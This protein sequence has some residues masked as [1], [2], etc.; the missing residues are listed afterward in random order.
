MDLQLV[1]GPVARPTSRAA[2][3]I[4]P[5]IG[6]AYAHGAMEFRFYLESGESQ[7][8]STD[9]DSSVA[10]DFRHD[11][12]CPQ[13]K[14]IEAIDDT[15]M[16]VNQSVKLLEQLGDTP[17][18]VARSLHVLGI[19][20][21]RN[22]VR[23]LNPI[24]RY[25]QSHISDEGVELDLIHGTAVTAKTRDRLTKAIPVPEPVKKFL[26]AFHSGEYPSCEMPEE[27]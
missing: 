22:T 9:R 27:K 23:F 25:L 7:P 13:E 15:R 21:V 12:G 14:S 19:Q 10:L 24:I 18:A 5:P 17:E 2:G 6:K 26:D 8:N 4:F 11:L 1:S 16:D 20:G 3:I